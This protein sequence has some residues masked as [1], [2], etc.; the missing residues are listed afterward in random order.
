MFLNILY[1]FSL[2]KHWHLFSMGFTS[3]R[4]LKTF[5]EIRIESN[6]CTDDSNDWKCVNTL[7]M[8]RLELHCSLIFDDQTVYL[9][10]YIGGDQSEP[11]NEIRS[12]GCGL[13]FLGSQDRLDNVNQNSNQTISFPFSSFHYILTLCLDQY[14]MLYYVVLTS[15]SS[16]S[17]G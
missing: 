8:T 4:L 1:L 9:H 3:I 15:R 16:N 6:F 11:P 10:I 13:C 14:G 17:N 5:T 12:V 2:V 7:C